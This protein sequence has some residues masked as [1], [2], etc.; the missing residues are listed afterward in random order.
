M[1]HKLGL[2]SLVCFATA[3][4]V[5]LSFYTGCASNEDP[6]DT[7]TGGG[8]GGGGTG[9][10]GTGGGGETGG[11][12]GGGTGGT[13]G[14]SAN[15]PAGQAS[16]VASVADGTVADNIQVEITGAI[17][18]TKKLVVYFGKSKGTCLWGM[19]V[20]DP[21]ADRG[22]MVVSYG[23]N[24]A[25]NASQADCPK[26]TDALPDVTPGDTVNIVGKV[27]PY[28]PSSCSPAPAKQMQ[29]TAC[30]ATVTG[31]VDAPAPV[32]V[33]KLDD[34][35]A[36]AAQYQGLLVRVENVVAE[37]VDGGA[38]GPYGVIQLADTELQVNDNFYY[39]ASGA[40]AFDP[41]QQFKSITGISHLSYCDWV[42]Q[43]RDKCTDFDPPSKNCSN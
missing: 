35:A 10:G 7:G 21:S 43:P 38:V 17:A 11:Q 31:K 27:S 37:N 30:S 14:S 40:P 9:G 15:C 39:A 13:G 26:G 22:L 2:H 16:T 33:T 29:V 18:T 34:L 42:L 3:S 19:F 6:P 8:T 12:D 32:V 1:K 23:E 5:A 20:K 28:A 25:A 36:G 4:M 41:S 24:A